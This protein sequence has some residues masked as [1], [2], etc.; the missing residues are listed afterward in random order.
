MHGETVKLSGELFCDI[1][2]KSFWFV[3]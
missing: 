2:G 3:I 1:W